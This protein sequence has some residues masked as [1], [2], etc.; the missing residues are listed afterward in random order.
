MMIQMV[1][2]NDV[3][4]EPTPYEGIYKHIAPSGYVFM[5]G[6]DC[7]GSVIWDWYE[8]SNNYYLKKVD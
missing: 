5:C 6:N 1:T 7:F 4:I 2:M 3:R 8:L